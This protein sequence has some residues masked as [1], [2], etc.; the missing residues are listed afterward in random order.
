MDRVA[1]DDEQ[2]HRAG[3]GRSRPSRTQRGEIGGKLVAESGFIP[4]RDGAVVARGLGEIDDQKPR[5]LDL[6]A[7]G[8]CGEGGLRPWP[9]DAT[10]FDAFVV[11]GN[12]VHA[13]LGTVFRYGDSFSIA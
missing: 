3:Y 8:E 13:H 7:I 12:E 1:G 9:K 5:M 2:R 6:D 4:G 10:A 11:D